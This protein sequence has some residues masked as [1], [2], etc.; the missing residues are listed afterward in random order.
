MTTPTPAQPWVV[1]DTGYIDV[2]VWQ[3]RTFRAS[4]THTGLLDP[5]GYD[6]RIGFRETFDGDLL[7]GGSVDDGSIVL[8][9]LPDSGGTLIT[10][11][12]ADETMEA[13]DVKKGYWDLVLESSGGQE[14]TVVA[15]MF[16]TRRMVAE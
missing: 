2:L 8:S 10:V 14:D 6:A 7:A 15:G 11:A 9:A 5:T 12:V 13:V 16:Y 1:Q 4:I 3:G